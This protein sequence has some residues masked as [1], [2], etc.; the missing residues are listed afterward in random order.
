M[1][2]TGNGLDITIRSYEEGDLE[3]IQQ[4]NKQQGWYN[5]V[6]KHA[7]ARAA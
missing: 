4:L 1:A 6:E 3:Q 5:L 7:A 2:Q